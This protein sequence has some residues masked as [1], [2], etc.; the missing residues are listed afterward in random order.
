M[1]IVPAPISVRHA[2]IASSM[3]ILPVVVAIL[4][5]RPAL[6]QAIQMRG[7]HVAKESCQE[8]ADFWQKL[9]TKAAQ[10]YHK[11]TL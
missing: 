11:T 4:I 10:Q 7:L 8:M 3:A 9:A 5:Q 6:R 2:L 1:S